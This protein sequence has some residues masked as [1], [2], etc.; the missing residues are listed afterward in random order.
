MF[1]SIPGRSLA[2][3]QGDPKLPRLREWIGTMQRR[4][5]SYEHLYT[6]PH[7]EPHLPAIER[8]PLYERPFFWLGCALMWLA[9]PL[10]LL[11]SLY[12][13]RRVRR[14]GLQRP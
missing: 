9:F 4:F 12:F 11:T 10:T 5:S 2:V 6:G 13:V 14:R 1:G 8:C 7:F 3:L